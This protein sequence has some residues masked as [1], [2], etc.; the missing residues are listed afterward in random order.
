VAVAAAGAAVVVA[1]VVPESPSEV[2]SGHRATE[3]VEENER[4]REDRESGRESAFVVVDETHEEPQ[5]APTKVA[6]E[7]RTFAPL[8]DERRRPLAHTSRDRDPRA[9]E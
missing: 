9:H 5:E 7:A 1:R 2:S 4:I 6:Q 8:A 3:E